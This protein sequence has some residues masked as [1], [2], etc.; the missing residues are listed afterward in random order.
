MIDNPGAA[1]RRNPF[2]WREHKSLPQSHFVTWMPG[3]PVPNSHFC[4]P[5]QLDA[6]GEHRF[7][8]DQSKFHVVRVQ[9]ARRPALL[10]RHGPESN[11]LC[12]FNNHI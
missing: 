5:L 3:Q 7:P 1:K 6:I 4:A 10:V 9:D 11:L 2:C 8:C 12:I